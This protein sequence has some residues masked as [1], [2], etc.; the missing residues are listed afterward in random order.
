MAK[1]ENASVHVH[2]GNVTILC[3]TQDGT[4][5][6]INGAVAVNTLADVDVKSLDINR[7]VAHKLTNYIAETCVHAEYLMDLTNKYV[8]FSGED[9]HGNKIG[10]AFAVERNNI[11][12]VLDLILNKEFQCGVS[13]FSVVKNEKELCKEI[14]VIK[15]IIAGK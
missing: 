2:N 4:L 10:G 12:D 14:N 1:I 8:K 5:L 7:G 11:S 13:I 6:L 3:D 9:K 15:D